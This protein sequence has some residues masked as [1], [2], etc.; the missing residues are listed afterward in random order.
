MLLHFLRNRLIE[1]RHASLPDLV[2]VAPLCKLKRKRKLRGHWL[3]KTSTSK[4]AR[5]GK[6]NRQDLNM[7]LMQ[8]FLGLKRS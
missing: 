5:N 2:A 1:L 4:I 6:K 3:L 7:R 8:R